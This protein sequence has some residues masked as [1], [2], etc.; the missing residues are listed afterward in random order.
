MDRV[1][2]FAF[3]PCQVADTTSLEPH[4]PLIQ[5]SNVYALLIEVGEWS[6]VNNFHNCSQDQICFEGDKK[7]IQSAYS[8]ARHQF[9]ILSMHPPCAD[10]VPTIA[11]HRYRVRLPP[12]R[13]AAPSKSGRSSSPSPSLAHPRL[14]S[15]PSSFRARARTRPPLPT[16]QAPWSPHVKHPCP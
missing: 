5:S 12:C 13:A 1:L 10:R 8:S 7:G 15:L 11:V 14:C 3:N 2:I 6:E 16:S 4:Y 9:T